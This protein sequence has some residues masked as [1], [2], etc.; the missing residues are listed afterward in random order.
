M[1]HGELR[2]SWQLALAAL[3]IAAG[4]PF[5]LLELFG[6]TLYVVL[7]VPSYL[8]FHNTVE[9]FSV[10][11]S[12][13]IFG[14]GWFSYSQS[15]DRHTLFLAVAFLG[16]G[17]MDFMHT[18][19]YAGMPPL[20]T[21]NTPNKSTQ[22]WIAVRL[23]SAAA[24][25][26]S[27]FVDER[28]RCRWLG[29]L[30]LLAGVLCIS[31][32]SFCAIVFRPDLV[33]DTFVPGVGLTPFK[34][35]SELV[36]I[37]LFALAAL[38]YL[39]RLT[40]SRDRIY[41]YYLSAFILCVVSELT[42][43]VYKSVFDS[44][45]LLGHLYKLFA[46][47][48]IYRGIFAAAI[49]RPYRQ[50]NQALG[51]LR[52]TNDLLVAI[53]D[54]IPHCIFWKDRRS[55]YLG[56]NREFAR[57]AGLA[58]PAE[59][60]GKCDYDLPWSREESEGYRADDR[61]VMER[62]QAKMHIIENLTQADGGVIW[63]DTSKMPLTDEDGAVRG[64]LGI[65][66]DITERKLSEERLSET[67]QF[68]QEIIT[69]AREGI[70]VY[71]RELRYLVW[72][73]YM[74]EISGIPASEVLGQRPAEVFPWLADTGLVRRLE[75]L[76]AGGAPAMVEFCGRHVS[77]RTLWLS[78]A[79]APLRSSSGDIIGVIGTVRDI[80]ERRGIEEQ[81]RQAQKLESVGRLA[82][83]VAHDF[84]NKL[85]VI[86]GCAEL[87]ARQTREAALLEHLR[88]IV[89][90]A[91]QSRDITRQ[92]LAFS[93]QQVVTPR[94]VQVNSMLVELKKSLGRLIGEDVSIELAPGEQLWSISIDP[95]QLDQIIMN[96]AVNARDAMPQGGTITIETAN[97]QF[98][99]PPPLHPEAP[100]G[101]Y[102]RI[103]CRD[104][105]VGMD[106]ETRAHVFEP[107]YTTKEQGKGTGLG[108]AT[109]YGIVRQNGG[110]ID[111]ETA[112]GAGSAFSIWLPRCVGGD[113]N[114]EPP[115]S[116]TRQQG[117]GTVL[118]VEDEDMVR[119]LTSTIL[120]SLG[121]R[122]LA[123]ADPRE[124]L[125]LAAN[126][127][128]AFDLVLTDVVMPGMRGP[129]M[130]QRMR[131]QRSGIKCIYMSGFTD[132]ILDEGS[133]SWE[134]GAFLKKPFQ[135]EEL[136]RVL[137]SVLGAQHR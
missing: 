23:F 131:R 14:V 15:R 48:L 128:V 117:A 83:G 96:L 136:A 1:P 112:P 106:A 94:T 44:F 110:F 56:C 82:G 45:N 10:M 21:P 102:V 37:A 93:R 38:A 87:A 108:L 79:S 103:T 132:A 137:A 78:D 12:L 9:I 116:A 7:D 64:V 6:S 127:D 84:N 97:E 95:V 27:A 74:E 16:I 31:A 4:I 90:A 34:K 54:S 109:V 50:L 24:F 122:C 98:D 25:L 43:T 41:L 35:G 28:C 19:A 18:L 40:A 76:M 105:G 67:L 47:L 133:G 53:M 55:V 114:H 3:A 119:E 51:E 115:R 99:G 57:T 104:T 68:N 62:N 20:I 126:P 2:S 73:P 49:K 135:T 86:M 124:A 120:E 39:K 63:I 61:E 11:V 33:P 134:G 130:M 13:S 80:T 121:Y 118:L 30:P 36:T 70:I 111:L 65:Y 77:G 100:P 42:F 88:L 5:L 85:T 26:A 8:T 71:D 75:G 92:L 91:E 123:T 113:E 58:D 129:E 46:F 81:L 72:N 107:F 66:E 17:L 52:H 125:E 22:F 89:K 32:V 29:R 69:S 101:G 60:V 59:I